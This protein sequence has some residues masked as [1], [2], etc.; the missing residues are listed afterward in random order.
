MTFDISTQNDSATTA[1]N[2]YVAKTLTGQTIPFNSQTYSFDVTV[3]GD[4]NFESN[5]T[6][7]VNV[8][9]VSGATVADGQ[10][11]GTITND[12]CAPPAADIVI[13]QVYGGGGNTG[14][15]YTNDF[16]ELYNQ[17]T[18]TVSLSGWS[19]Q[20]ISATGTGTWAVTPLSGS[21]APG[22]YYL[23]QEAQ[24][25]GGTTPLPTPDATGTIAMSAE[26]GKVAL[27]SSMTPFSGA[28]PTCAVDLVGYGSTASCFEGAGP[29]GTL[30]N[31]TAALRKRRG[32][33]DTN[34]NNADFTTGSPN[35]RNIASPLNSCVI[36]SLAIH[37]I[38]GSGAASP[39]VGQEVSTT[40]I[41]TARKSN[42]FFLQEPDASVDAN[43]AT[44]EGVFVFT[45]SA[46]TVAVRDAVT[47]NLGTVSEFFNLTEVN[48]SS[49]DIAV[50]SSGNSLPAPVMLTTSIL[51]P[52][53]TVAQLERFEGMRLHADSLTSVGPTNQFGEFFTVLT[54]V[55]RPFREE[56]VEASFALPAGAPCCVPRFDEN[57][58]RLMVDSDGQAGATSIAVTTGVTVTN[59]TGPLDFTFDDYKVLPDTP[60]STT[61]NATATPVRLPTSEEFTVGSFNMERFLTATDVT[62]RLNKVSL[63]IRNVMRSPDIIGVEEVGDITLLDTIAAKLNADTVAG[64]DPNPGYV[65]YL[66]EGNDI[67]G[68][69]VGFLVKSS[70]VSVNSVT[71]VGKTATFIDPNDN[72]VDIL[73]DRPPLFLRATVQPPAGAPF[74]VTV[75]VNH[76]RSLIDISDTGAT[77]NRVRAKR[78]A[79]AEF[80]ANEIQMIQA[81]E[82]VI[83]VGDY[84]AFQ[85]SDGYVDVMGTIRGDP[86]PM[87]EVVL[88][89]SDLV[90]PDLTD[91]IGGLVADQQ[92]SF[93]FGGNAQAID[94]VLVDPE[95]L[96]RNSGFGY[97]RNNADFP[98]AFRSDMTRSE[99]VSDHDMPVAY[100]SSPKADTTTTV[101]NATAVFSST[102]QSVMLTAN[103]TADALTVNEGT[104]TFTVTNAGNAVVG[105]PAMGNVSGGVATAT[106]TLPGGTL[107]QALTITGDFSGGD[108]THPSSG[109]GTLSV[110]YGICLLYDPTRAVKSGAAYPIKIQ[111]CDI[112]G[113]N[114]SSAGTVVTA[115]GVGL[116]STTA[117][118]DVMDAG[119]ANPDNNFRFDSTLGGTGGYIYNLKTTGLTTGT[120]NLYFM[121]GSDPTLHTVQFQVK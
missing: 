109:T 77:G 6:F 60:P 30:S 49:S 99:R 93:V 29:T 79:Q 5:E 68:I 46:P 45:S 90:T 102:D 41:V 86:T 37:D 106:Y 97:A 70:T 36:L 7:F 20:Y 91:L 35:P 110:T 12:D 88:S 76:L 17:G 72:S 56:G 105:L 47:I 118:G 69:D 119:N 95:M 8:T 82:N 89:S 114:L 22:G 103:V 65:A 10:G 16:I 13:S 28:C 32:C 83:S 61:S 59:V 113:S 57:P 96:A 18:T 94:H 44:S 23:V 2:D 100:F 101:S 111:L 80:L 116:I 104:V 19:V 54:G 26:N 51:D 62:N 63:A 24:G 34:N 52:G 58:E 4:T 38:Q 43:P 67:G 78:R 14:A 27:S 112:D 3:N 40:G 42:G 1:D 11:V 81:T 84:N 120:Y 31:T 74:P 73:N 53:G 108:F 9:N 75:I 87:N 71:Q 25:A 33:V 115:V 50:G 107:P 48:A 85:I 64:G 21:I 39:H 98:E 15:T 92:Y 66:E 55:D 117:Y 121:A